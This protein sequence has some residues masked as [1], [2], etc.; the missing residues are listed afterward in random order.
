MKVKVLFV[1]VH[2]SARSQIAEAFFKKIGGN[3]FEVDS[4]GLE[5][6]EL[7][8]L[9]V[10][11][12]K[13]SG[14]DISKNKTKGVIDFYKHGKSFDYVITLCGEAEG[15]CPVFPNTKEALHWPFD[16]PSSFSGTYEEKLE[17]TKIVRDKIRGKIIEWIKEITI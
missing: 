7:N 4:A 17:K 13:D 16:D 8:S 6:G 10:D 14:I 12:M 11:A 2:N 5:P 15:K 9:V 1:C 3:R